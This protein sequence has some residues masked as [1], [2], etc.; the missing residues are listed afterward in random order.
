MLLSYI[1]LYNKFNLYKA[2][3][4]I[5]GAI[6]SWYASSYLYCSKF[7]TAFVSKQ[8]IYIPLLHLPTLPFL[9]NIL[10]LEAK[11]ICKRFYIL[12][13][14][15]QVSITKYRDGIVRDVSHIVVHNIILLKVCYLY[16]EVGVPST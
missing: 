7:S 11:H 3:L 1:A 2:S 16:F 8:Y 4:K 12:H 10:F 14:F 9:Y 13:L 6:I 5:N 15:I